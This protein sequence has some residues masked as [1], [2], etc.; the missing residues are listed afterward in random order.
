MDL[1]KYI[2]KTSVAIAISAAMATPAE[3]KNN[4]NK[5]ENETTIRVL[6]MTT[7]YGGYF[8]ERADYVENEEEGTFRVLSIE[9]SYGN[10]VYHGTLE[11]QETDQGYL[12]I[13]EVSMEDYIKGVV[14][15]EMPASYEEEAL[16][17]QAVC[18][19]TY[20]YRQMQEGRLQSYGADVDDSVSFQVYNNQKATEKTD[21]AVTDTAG[22]IMTYE[23]EPIEAYFFSTSSGTTSTDEVWCEETAPCLKSIVTD[24]DADMPWYRW[25]VTFSAEKIE[26]LLMQNGYEIGKI[27]NIDIIR[28][29]QGGAATLC[30]FQGS[31]GSV[32]IENE[33]TIRSLL[34]PE[35]LEIV[36]QDGSVVTNFHILPS[37]YFSCE[38]VT[39]EDQLTGFTFYGGGYGHG[40]G[41]S[42]NGANEMAKQEYEWLDIL[43]YYFEDFKIEK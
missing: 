26:E 18:A 20:A 14:P 3:E 15:S 12:L 25:Q 28:K 38:A 32:Q 19:R 16:K 5:T 8:H 37:A 2:I 13:N 1:I 34:S 40:V 23:N 22:M 7:G 29:S 31:E 39:E 24:F 30:E 6:L 27:E 10:P 36:R 35:G 11:V 41:M 42:Q 4:I 21:Q 17:A 43:N 33:Y 9:R